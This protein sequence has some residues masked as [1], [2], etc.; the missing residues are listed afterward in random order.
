MPKQHQQGAEN[1]E[2]GIYGWATCTCGWE[3]PKRLMRRRDWGNQVSGDW[4]RH[5]E[6]PAPHDRDE[7]ES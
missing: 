6:E 7:T 4:L 3:G 1:D 2:N 5:T